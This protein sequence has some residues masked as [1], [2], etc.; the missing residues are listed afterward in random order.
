MYFLNKQVYD[1]YIILTVTLMAVFLTSASPSS[2]VAHKTKLANFLFTSYTRNTQ[3]NSLVSV[4]SI[5][6]LGVWLSA[7]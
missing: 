4:V 7:A 6:V 2:D 3:K 1:G 5:K